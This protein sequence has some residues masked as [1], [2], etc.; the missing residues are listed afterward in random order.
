[1]AFK[2]ILFVEFEAVFVTGLDLPIEQKIHCFKQLLL[3][4]ELSNSSYW[5]K[6]YSEFSKSTPVTS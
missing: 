5:P 1:M 3:Y 2:I 6:A 4:S